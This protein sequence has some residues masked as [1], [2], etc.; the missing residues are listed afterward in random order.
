M[1]QLP[2]ELQKIIDEAKRRSPESIEARL[3]NGGEKDRNAAV[4]MIMGLAA[5]P[6]PME[7]KGD[8]ILT[9]I[10][11]LSICTQRD[12]LINLCIEGKGD[13]DK[14]AGLV[15]HNGILAN[16]EAQALREEIRRILRDNS[17]IE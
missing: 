12:I 11:Y 16:E 14:I 15:I 13:P 5:S 7:R 1:N 10:N 8:W 6:I 2:P 9:A 17:E 4:G 3:K